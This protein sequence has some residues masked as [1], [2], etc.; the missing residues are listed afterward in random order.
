MDQGNKFAVHI[1]LSFIDIA[2]NSAAGA[3]AAATGAHVNG[4]SLSKEI[5]Q[6]GALG[7]AIKSGAINFAILISSTTSIFT[8]LSI[9]ILTSSF[10]VALLVTLAIT[11]KLMSQTPMELL[12]A[13]AAAAAPLMPGTVLLDATQAVVSLQCIGWDALAGYT[14]ARVAHN[15]GYIVCSLKAATAAGGIYG[16]IVYVAKLPWKCQETGTE[17]YTSLS[18]YSRYSTVMRSDSYHLTHIHG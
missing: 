18:P 9:V 1:F 16:S 5:L 4:S 2:I 11:Q 12:V 8:Q 15:H 13:A 3:A 10:G 17:E 14:F 6:L 7:G